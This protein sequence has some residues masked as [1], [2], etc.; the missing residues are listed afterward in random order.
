MGEVGWCRPTLGAFAVRKHATMAKVLH[1]GSLHTNKAGDDSAEGGYIHLRETPVLP[2]QA[3]LHKVP[4]PPRTRRPPIRRPKRLRI[5]LTT[6]RLTP[7]VPA[8]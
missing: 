8:T 5:G 6:A 2:E 7:W 3:N 1:N 4:V